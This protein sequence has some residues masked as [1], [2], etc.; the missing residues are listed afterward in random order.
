M[1]V[2]CSPGARHYAQLK[3]CGVPVTDL[4]VDGKA[5]R[6]AVAA[7]RSRLREKPFDIIHGFNNATVANTVRAAAGFAIRVVA[8]RG[9][10][11]NVSFFN[12]AS[13][14]TYLHPRVDRVV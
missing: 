14:M 12:P 7:I 3:D 1:E 6:A 2:M 4:Q 10:V 13:W 9:I 8:Y 5:D 11:G